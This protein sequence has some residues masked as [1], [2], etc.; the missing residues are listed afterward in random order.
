MLCSLCGTRPAAT[1]DGRCRICAAFRRAA[2]GGL[3]ATPIGLDHLRSPVGLGRAACVLLG[4]VAVADALSIVTGV[5]ARLL[6]GERTEYGLAAVDETTWTH[7]ETLYRS[8]GVLQTVAFLATAV[9]FLAW[10]HR[11][12]LNAEVFD[13]G[14]HTMRPGWTIGAWFVPIGNLWLP[15]RV[16]RGIWTAS[17]LPGT[18]GDRAETPR[19]L[20]HAWWGTLVASEVLSRFASVRYDRA[21]TVDDVVDALDLVAFCDALDIVAAVLAI[22]LVRRLTAMQ[23]ERAALGALPV[24]QPLRAH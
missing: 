7:A 2:P 22:L 19:P 11:V 21:E 4:A 16:V 15:Y 17:V 10:L 5:R 23:G 1:A 18:P 3:M 12:R 24:A 13:P 20:L 6:L 9:L 8:A 14:A